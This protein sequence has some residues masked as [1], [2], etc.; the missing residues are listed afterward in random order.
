MA[1]KKI[2]KIKKVES[3]ALVLSQLD[4]APE[5][6]Q[7]IFVA[8]PKE[9]IKRRVVRGK[10]EADYVEVGY[11]IARL[12]EIFGAVNWNFQVLRETLLDKSVAVYGE[13]TIKDHKKGFSITKGQY[14]NHDRYPEIPIGDT[15]KAAASDALKKCASLFG[16]ALDVYWK[17]LERVGKLED[18]KP[19]EK[20]M[21]KEAA[22]DKTKAMIGTQESVDILRQ[23]KE[24]IIASTFGEK[25]KAELTELIDKKINEQEQKAKSG[26][27]L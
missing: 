5:Q 18:G 6:K 1:K 13:L 15:L 11:V 20:G 22:F 8:T 2:K 4:L 3:R 26:T 23:W 25:Q 9:F 16:I 27:L 17:E 12:N 7:K 10:K 21:S 24:K 19:K 14:G